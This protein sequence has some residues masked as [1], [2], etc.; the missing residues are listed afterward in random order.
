MIISYIVVPF[1]LGERGKLTPSAPLKQKSQ[2]SAVKAADR[3]GATVAGVVVLEQQADP[4]NDFYAEPRLVYRCGEV[5][6]ELV[7]QLAS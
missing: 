5:P 4:L 2:P 6:P 3:L 7:E 1:R